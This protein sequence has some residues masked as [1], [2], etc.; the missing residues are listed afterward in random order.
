MKTIAEWRA[1]KGLTQFQLAVRV[2][3]TV[4]S[5]YDWESGRKT[6]G[7]VRFRAL[8]DALGVKM[9]DISIVRRKANA[10]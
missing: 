2:G 3:V 6:P 10:R 4:G 1:E 7:A 9:D 8:A 5:I